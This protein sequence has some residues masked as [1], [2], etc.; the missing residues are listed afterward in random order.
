MRCPELVPH[1]LH[2]LLDVDVGLATALIVLAGF[3]LIKGSAENIVKT[4]LMGEGLDLAPSV[5]LR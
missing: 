4:K 2:G 1:Q 3:V 5:V